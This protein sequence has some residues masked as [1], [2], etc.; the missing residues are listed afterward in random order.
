MSSSHRPQNGRHFLVFDPMNLNI[1]MQTS[2]VYI[3]EGISP[4]LSN[5]CFLITYSCGW[6]SG[7]PIVLGGSAIMSR[8]NS[9]CMSSLVVLGCLK[10]AE[11]FMGGWWGGIISIAKTLSN[12]LKLV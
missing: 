12:Q 7:D 11:K 4:K 2:I 8:F 9:P 5:G 3:R 6:R 10:V 1:C